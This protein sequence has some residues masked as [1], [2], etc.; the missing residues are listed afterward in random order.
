MHQHPNGASNVL[1]FTLMKWKPV[2]DETVE[3]SC[4]RAST[5]YSPKSANASHLTSLC[6]ISFAFKVFSNLDRK[7]KFC[8]VPKQ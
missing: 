8:V 6:K 5:H 1:Y 3:Q 2:S 7:P 4:S